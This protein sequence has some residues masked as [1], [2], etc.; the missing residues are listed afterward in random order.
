VLART[1]S[2]EA[3]D[4][5]LVKDAAHVLAD[6]SVLALDKSV[7]TVSKEDKGGL[8]N[9]VRCVRQRHHVS[10]VQAV[11]V[12]QPLRHLKPWRYLSL[13]DL[14]VVD[15]RSSV[16]LWFPALSCLSIRAWKTSACPLGL[17]FTSSCT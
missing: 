1:A 12:A 3:V 17:L 2:D 16:L 5:C 9:Q 11:E 14:A 13:R 15:L 7:E 8:G 4:F 6:R 10:H